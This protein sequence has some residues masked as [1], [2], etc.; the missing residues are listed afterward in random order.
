MARI[1]FERVPPPG[2]LVRLAGVA[3]VIEHGPGFAGIE[4]ADAVIAGSLVY[5]AD[6][7][8]SA[9][10]AMVI[11][12]TGIGVDRVDL[13]AAT[14][15]G[16]VVCNTPDAP[17]VSTA[18]HT[19]ALILAVAKRLDRIR[20]R[21]AAAEPRL[22]ATNDAVELAGKTLGVVGFGRVGRRV[23]DVGRAFGMEVVAYDPFVPDEVFAA[24]RV[25][26]MSDLGGLL[27]VADVVT[28]HLPHTPET[29][30]L[31]DRGF[32]AAMRDGA[33]LVNAARGELVDHDALC[34]ALE[35]GRLL[36][37]GLDVTVPEPLPGDHPLLH[38]DDVVVTPH[39]ATATD[40]GRLRLVEAA[41]ANALAVLGGRR[42]DSIVNPE[43]WERRRTP[44]VT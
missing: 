37:V 4:A 16:I 19:W 34:D 15:A 26:R 7:I 11:S 43:V 42:P 5:D 38:R 2:A 12:R 33:I 3:D 24:A 17:T 30:R 6:V 1:W 40:R 32:L 9:V 41:V 14:R 35:A 8:A 28:L 36:G 29:R 10:R 21:A 20:A 39:V 27:G 31:V 25:G 22:Y 23:A 44:H 13:D 18:E